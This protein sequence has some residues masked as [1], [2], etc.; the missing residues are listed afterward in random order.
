MT[1]TIE[2]QKNTEHHLP[3]PTRHVQEVSAPASPTNPRFSVKED[4][5]GSTSMKSSVQRNVRNSL[6]EQLPLLSQP[7]YKEGGEAPTPPAAPEPAPEQVEEEE[8]PV[9]GK[10]GKGKGGKKGGKGGKK[11]KKED[12]PA[13]AE[14]T[15][16]MQVLDELWPKKEPLGI[17]K[18]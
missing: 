7:A 10:G 13:G 9:K 14:D 5:S 16:E 12:A 4:V 17:T 18:W 1:T 15:E 11:G 3:Q 8:E 6:L 2:H